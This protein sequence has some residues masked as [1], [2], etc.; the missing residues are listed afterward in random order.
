MSAN[1]TILISD[2]ELLTTAYV[3]IKNTGIYNRDM[4]KGDER[5]IDFKD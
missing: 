3:N 5:I 1:E 4:A 2:A